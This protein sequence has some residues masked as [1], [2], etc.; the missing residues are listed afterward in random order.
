M[1]EQLL[2]SDK[3]SKYPIFNLKGSRKKGKRLN[4][5]EKNYIIEQL[6]LFS[7][8]DGELTTYSL[9]D[10][11]ELEDYVFA[12]KGE[13]LRK[14]LK[15]FHGIFYKLNNNMSDLGSVYCFLDDGHVKYGKGEAIKIGFSQTPEKRM[16]QLQKSNDTTNYWSYSKYGKS[17]REHINLTCLMCSSKCL[18][19][20]HEM[21][22]HYAFRSKRIVKNGYRTEY[23]NLS[24]KD[25]YVLCD[26]LS[27]MEEVASF[28]LDKHSF[29]KVLRESLEH[30][31]HEQ[32]WN[33]IV[34]FR[35]GKSKKSK[36]TFENG[37]FEGQ[38]CSK[39][40]LGY[41]IHI[42]KNSFY[43]PRTAYYKKILEGCINYSRENPTH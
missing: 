16:A 27:A 13:S 4:E 39:C 15:R 34:S 6:I 11:C 38:I 8:G 40:P 35:K 22:L 17:L 18:T 41:L 19:I 9:E 12:I 2:I 37:P 28:F 26:Y 20:F 24:H 31:P 36:A 33:E 30:E 25:M 1:N 43:Y 5:I 21:M 14:N 23:F 32:G 7:R 42:S 3:N 10:I 29:T